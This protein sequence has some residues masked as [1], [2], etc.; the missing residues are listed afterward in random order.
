MWCSVND[1]GLTEKSSL[2]TIKCLHVS[3]C[4]VE[5]APLANNICSRI[6]YIDV[7][8]SIISINAVVTGRRTTFNKY[9]PIQPP[10]AALPQLWQLLSHMSKPV[11]R[12]RYP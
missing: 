1:S 5:R 6:L 3:Y 9:V 11:S 2:L 8:Q 4:L 7:S 12:H 10:Q